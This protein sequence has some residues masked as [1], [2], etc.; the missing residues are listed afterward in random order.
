[1]TFPPRYSTS[2]SRDNL[3]LASNLTVRHL[4]ES[5]LPNLEWDG[6]YAHFR[7]IFKDAYDH[8]EKGEAVLWVGQLPSEGIVAQLFVQ[9]ISTRS[10]LADG[11][12]RAYIYGFRVRHPYRRA[13]VGTRMIQTAE[14]DLRR[15][16]FRYLVL[17]V[18]RDN[19]EALRLYQ[20]LG[21]RVVS[22]E[23]GIWSYIDHLGRRQ[24]VSEPAWLMEKKL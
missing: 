14:A 3:W 22:A 21:F 16:G 23:P 12:T 17:M 13:G 24:H 5:D 18:A 2:T 11:T 20:R 4:M 1:M 9:L 7:R 6:E 15:R 10:D 8:F 19:R